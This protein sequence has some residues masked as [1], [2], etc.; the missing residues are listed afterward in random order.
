MANQHVVGVEFLVL[1]VT[2]INGVLWSEVQAVAAVFCPLAATLVCRERVV[3]PPVKVGTISLA[4]F[5]AVFVSLSHPVSDDPSTHVSGHCLDCG[6]SVF[7]TPAAGD[8]L[9]GPAKIFAKSYLEEDAE[10]QA[11]KEVPANAY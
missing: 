3:M 7:L 1:P 2:R 8:S 9:V 6:V 4:Y 10:I 11:S 5:P